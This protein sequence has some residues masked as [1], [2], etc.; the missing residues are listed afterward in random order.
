MKYC[1]FT[2]PSL[3][4]IYNELGHIVPRDPSPEKQVDCKSA[5]TESFGKILQ[6]TIPQ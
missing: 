2:E 1:D 6:H 5:Q 3:S 4:L